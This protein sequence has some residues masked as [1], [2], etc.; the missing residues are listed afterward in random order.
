M[1]AGLLA[2]IAP[3]R[4]AWRANPNDALKGTQAAGTTR[5]RWAARDLLFAAQVALCCMVVTA[6]LVAFRGLARAISARPGIEA[7]STSLVAFDLGM[8]RYSRAD[9]TRFKR[10][11]LE[12]VLQLPGVISA[13]YASSVPLSLD[14]SMTTVF[15]EQ[16]ADFT[17]RNGALASYYHVSPGYLSAAGTRLLRGR[18]FT[19]QDGPDAPQV[20]IVNE[21][22]ARKVAG[23]ADAVGRRFRYPNRELVEIVGVVEDGKYMSL[24]EEPRPALFRPADQWYSPETV[25]IARTPVDGALANQMRQVIAR[26]DSTLPVHRVGSLAQHIGV[27]FFPAR[28]ATV[29][30]AA[31]GVL[32][33]MLAITGI[34]GLASYSVSRR[35]REIGIRMA[36]GARRAHVLRFVLGRTAVL[37][38]AGSAVGVA[39]GAAAS[40]LLA[41]IVYQASPRDPLVIGA[42]TLTMVVIALASAL[43]PARRAVSTDPVRALRQD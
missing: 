36:V 41:N 39:A 11:A 22:F 43:G 23:T 2:G 10:Q 30:L 7:Q 25:L 17:F 33:A 12:S 19:W 9:G 6:C 38:A 16:A 31:F 4:Q 15:S 37:L 40:R 27:A 28:A 26:L 18:D 24:T 42:V 8:S 5:R 1:A 34:Y 13:G 21:T 14:Q 29:A 20:A 3:A 35:V 32:A